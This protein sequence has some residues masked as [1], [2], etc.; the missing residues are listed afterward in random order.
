MDMLLGATVAFQYT[1]VMAS[2]AGAIHSACAGMHNSHLKMEAQT[3]WLTMK[4]V[5]T[6]DLPSL[7]SFDTIISP[8][9]WKSQKSESAGWGPRTALQTWT[10]CWQ[11]LRPRP[12]G[13]NVCIQDSN[14]C[15]LLHC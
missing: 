15:V 2:V 5:C 11:V 13:S 12:A 1:A 8:A 6:V 14:G 3:C 9:A 4:F 10:V 7:D